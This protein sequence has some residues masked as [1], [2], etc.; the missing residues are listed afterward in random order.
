MILQ[1]HRALFFPEVR[2]RRPELLQ[3]EVLGDVA[4]ENP[5][6][7]VGREHRQPHR[8]GHL[9]RLPPDGVDDKEPAT[10]SA[11][12]MNAQVA[13]KQVAERIADAIAPTVLRQIAEQPELAQEVLETTTAP[14]K[15]SL[16][17]AA[18]EVPRREQ[19][20]MNTSKLVKAAIDA[21]F[22]TPTAGKT[23]K[24]FL[25]GRFFTEIKTARQPCVRKSAERGKFEL[26]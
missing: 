26:A 21:K 2:E 1:K 11:S 6:D 18:L 5:V 25:Y 22:W 9:A 12:Q 13:Q 8:P 14:Q 20:P 4:R 19:R 3:R 15:R 24:Q 10:V 17:N 23:P 7:D 16:M